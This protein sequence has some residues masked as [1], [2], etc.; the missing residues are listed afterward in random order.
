MDVRD[1]KR[2]RVTSK[3]FQV[4]PQ[5]PLLG[6]KIIPSG[7]N[8]APSGIQIAPRG[9]KIAP[10]GPELLPSGPTNGTPNCRI[11][12]LLSSRSDRLGR[13]GQA[14]CAK[15]QQSIA[16]GPVALD[17]DFLVAH[18]VHQFKLTANATRQTSHDERLVLIHMVVWLGDRAIL[19]TV[20][21]P[22]ALLVEIPLFRPMF[23][24]VVRRDW[25]PAHRTNIRLTLW[26]K[27]RSM[28]WNPKSPTS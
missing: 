14:E 24:H 23:K 6:P 4:D 20:S 17:L 27:A 28:L 19:A 10:R 3:W 16:V 12:F 13:E 5:W 21:A 8:I 25:H 2:P 26:S 9:P 15:R 7:T 11:S 22:D 18:F 1:P